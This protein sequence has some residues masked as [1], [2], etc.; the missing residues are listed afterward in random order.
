[1]NSCVLFNNSEIK[2]VYINEKMQKNRQLLSN[3]LRIILY[4]ELY[5]IRL[6]P[7]IIFFSYLSASPELVGI[8]EQNRSKVLECW[9]F[10]TQLK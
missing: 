9:V 6:R 1:M 8:I 3:F 10:G 7:K 2:V 4:E 5:T